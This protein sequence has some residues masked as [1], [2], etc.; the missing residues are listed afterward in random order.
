MNVHVIYIERQKHKDLQMQTPNIQYT[1][2]Q[3]A[4]ILRE[5]LH[6]LH[7]KLIIIPLSVGESTT[8]KG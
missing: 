1:N 2:I 5:S 6:L 7:Q 8:L 4:Q 3:T